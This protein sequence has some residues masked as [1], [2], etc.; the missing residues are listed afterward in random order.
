MH[1]DRQR[2]KGGKREIENEQRV[3]G[4]RGRAESSE[5]SKKER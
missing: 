2:G 4:K 1:G 5:G 3:K